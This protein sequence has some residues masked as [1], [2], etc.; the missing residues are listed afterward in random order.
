MRTLRGFLAPLAIV[1]AAVFGAPSTS[2][3]GIAVGVSIGVAPPP[4]PAYLQPPIP[5]PGYIW[6]PGYW[7]WGPYGYYWVPGAWVLPPA[8]GLLWTPGYWGW[9]AGGF[10]FHAGYWGPTV[11]FYGGINYGF[12]YFGAGFAGGY[13]H[14]GNFFYNRA[15]T[16]IGNTRIVNVYNRS[17]TIN[18][19][20][21]VA[22]NG[23][24]GGA[25]A[26]PTPAEVAAA[27]AR[28]FG[29][30]AAQE[31]QVSL[32]RADRGLSAKVNHG[33]PPV[34]A[35]KRVGELHGRGVVAPGREAAEHRAVA[36]HGRD[37]QQRAGRERAVEERAARERAVQQPRAAQERALRERAARQQATHARTPRQQRAGRER[38]LEQRATTRRAAQQRVMQQRS[39]ERQRAPAHAV[40][41]RAGRG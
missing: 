21:R 26:R 3:A 38:A 12:G 37:Q 8:V 17:V 10:I 35:T 33:R 19:H 22:F 11:G 24:R 40:R 29:P 5:G 13:W 25:T 16:N 41:E 23:G 27:R 30:T 32:A 1:A 7:A 36:A 18:N 31:R 9:G 20:S 39:V 14:G 28:R 34:A 2:L 4:L 6:M 15:V